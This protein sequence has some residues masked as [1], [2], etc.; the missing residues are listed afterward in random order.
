M[1]E[2]DRTAIDIEARFVN[3]PK[4]LARTEFVAAV[5]RVFRRG[6]AREHLCGECFVNFP[7]VDLVD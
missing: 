2:G 5:I 4:R 3:F 7:V 1:A 6:E